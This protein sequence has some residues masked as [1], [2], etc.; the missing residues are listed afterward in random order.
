MAN[1]KNPARTVPRDEHGR[2]TAD[3]PG[4]KLGSRNR[5]SRLLEQLLKQAQSHRLTIRVD[6]TA[7][8]Q[9]GD[10]TREVIA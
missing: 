5:S 1:I 10:V 7:P 4:R 3:N 9:E 8:E 2:F 6:I